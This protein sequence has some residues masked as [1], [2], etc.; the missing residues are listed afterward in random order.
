MP[1]RF[2]YV[3]NRRHFQ[4]I[5]KDKRPSTMIGSI[6]LATSCADSL[7]PLPSKC[8]RNQAYYQQH[9]AHLKNSKVSYNFKIEVRKENEDRLATIRENIAT[10]RRAIQPHNKSAT[11]NAD[12]MEALTNFWLSH[13]HGSDP[14]VH[15]NQTT[16]Y[17]IHSTVFSSVDK[18]FR[19]PE[20][21]VQTKTQLHSEC[22]KDDEIYLVCGS[23]LQLLFHHLVKGV[24]KCG[25]PY[26]AST[27]SVKR[28]TK[29][30]HCVKAY[31]NCV[32]ES[33]H[34][35]EW[36]S[37]SIVT[38]PSAGKYYVNLRYVTCTTCMT[39]IYTC[40]FTMCQ[41]CIPIQLFSWLHM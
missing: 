20:T 32:A 9:K 2:V 26:D 12:I 5:A 34:T 14:T 18:E 13:N 23:A 1:K 36:F 11:S 41:Y 19:P 3:I 29:N 27:F 4:N 16:N 39:T 25:K 38:G 40:T 8:E 31:W 35:T 28:V 15:R 30:N 33:K 22:C 17:Q 7:S 6:P 37:S 10:V 21:L 24:C